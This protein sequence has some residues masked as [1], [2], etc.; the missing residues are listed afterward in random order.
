MFL[1]LMTML[2]IKPMTSHF[3]S[4]LYTDQVQALKKIRDT[5][6]DTCQPL[7]QPRFG[8]TADVAV[9]QGAVGPFKGLAQPMWAGWLPAWL[10]ACMSISGFTAPPPNHRHQILPQLPTHP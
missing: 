9:M 7:C 1:N 8:S 10:L 2:I 4:E 6:S 3:K 5:V